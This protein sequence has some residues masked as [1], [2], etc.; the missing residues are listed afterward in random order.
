[1]SKFLAWN[2]PIER[3]PGPPCSPA[4][5]RH[6]VQRPRASDVVIAS[7]NQSSFRGDP[8]HELHHGASVENVHQL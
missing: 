3:T 7:L 2:H 1:M 5:P 4:L 8:R 6:N